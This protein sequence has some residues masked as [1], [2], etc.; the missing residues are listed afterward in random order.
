[1]GCPEDDSTS[2]T[3]RIL[4]RA[5]IRVLL[6]CSE[7]VIRAALRA[8]IDGHTDTS[9]VGEVDSLDAALAAILSD[10]PDVT[11]LDPDH[12]QGDG[13]ADLLRAA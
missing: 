13:V 5:V 4:R 3:G 12:Y 1:M 10:R 9:V 11:V 7:R 2:R 6:V 8:L